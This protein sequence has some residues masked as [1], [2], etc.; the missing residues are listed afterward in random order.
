MLTPSS[1]SQRLAA[2]WI[3]PG[4][5]AAMVAGNQGWTVGPV[6]IGQV[7]SWLNDLSAVVLV[8][9]RFRGRSWPLV[10]IGATLACKAAA[11][12]PPLAAT[13]DLGFDLGLGLL[14]CAAGAVLVSERPGLVY[15]QVVA[16]AVLSIPLM[17]V[18]ITGV[19][20]WSEALNTEN[21]EGAGPPQPTL[22]VPED[23]LQYRTSQA[24]PSGFTHSNNFL[25]LLA[26]LAL[27]LHF[28][29]LKTA[30]LTYRDLIICTFALL[31]MA[32]IVLLMYAVVLAWKGITGTHWERHRILRV[33]GLTA[34]LLAAYAVLFPGLLANN[35]SWYKIS[36]SFFIRVNDFADLLPQGSAVRG[37]LQEQLAGTP[38]ADWKD[39]VTLSGYAQIIA[40]VPYLL[41]S[42][43]LLAPVFVKGIRRVR[44]RYPEIVDLTVLSLL[45]VVLYPTAVPLF[46]AQ[47]FAFVAGFGLL[48]FFTVWQGRSF[49]GPRGTF[50]PLTRAEAAR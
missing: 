27:V 32:K 18:Q 35:I 31:T 11:Q 45:L 23:E 34:I 28:S 6:A 16:I 5:I 17:L 38:R 39:A 47:I 46:R 13:A 44:L 19:A 48:P 36:Y 22:L 12:I 14:F 21:V 43:V 42:G 50:H 30:R 29:R 8:L 25:S 2:R 20:A 49:Q 15:R 40:I 10:V 9:G 7:L 3:F 1:G 24:R 37:W 41:V 4:L 26:G 33:T